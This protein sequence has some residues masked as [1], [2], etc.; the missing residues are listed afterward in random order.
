MIPGASFSLA[1]PTQDFLGILK[2]APPS[3]STHLGGIFPPA[4]CCY[5]RQAFRHKRFPAFMY[6]KFQDQRLQRLVCRK[7]TLVSG[8]PLKST[9]GLAIGTAGDP[10]HYRRHY[11]YPLQ[12]NDIRWGHR[13]PSL[14]DKFRAILRCRMRHGGGTS[15]RSHGSGSLRP[16]GDRADIAISWRLIRC[17]RRLLICLLGCIFSLLSRL[18]DGVIATAHLSFNLP[19]AL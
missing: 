15:N 7:V 5:R 9:A 14:T 10:L 1:G 12:R 8:S 2:G 13:E 17:R 19:H 4:S 6:A 16:N 18:Q 3:C 11:L